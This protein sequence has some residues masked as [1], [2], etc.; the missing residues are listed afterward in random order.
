MIDVLVHS[1]TW[2]TVLT[3]ACFGL[4]FLLQRKIRKIWCNPLL[5]S[6]IVIGAFLLISHI[7]YENYK[8]SSSVLSWLL[9]PATVSLALPMFEQWSLLKKNWPAILGGIAAGVVTSLL[10]T[11]LLSVF[12][13]LDRTVAVSVLPKSVTTAIGSDVSAALDG[14]P[15]LTVVLIILTGIFGNMAAPWLCRHLRLKNAVSRGVAIG[16]ASHA[17]GT[18]RAIEMG[19]TE[20]AMSSLAIAVAGIL[21]A[22]L[23]PLA[24]LILP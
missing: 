23:A 12:F 9:L 16:T 2:G 24:A 10:C 13:R 22:F 14:I 15:A 1:S 7:P 8:S 20:G 6:S 21:T 5:M 4:F 3:V 17:I 11:V 19:E 18:T